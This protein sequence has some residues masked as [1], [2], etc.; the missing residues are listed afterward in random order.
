MDPIPTIEE[1]LQETQDAWRSVV[2]NSNVW[3]ERY[4]SIPY[5]ETIRANLTLRLLKWAQSG[6][7]SETAAALVEAIAKLTT[8]IYRSA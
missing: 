8:A 2:G 7:D 4:G 1:I 6:E 3:K 5:T